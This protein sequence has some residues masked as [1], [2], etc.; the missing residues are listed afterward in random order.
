VQKLRELDR[1][2]IGVGVKA[3]TS[4][5]LP[6]ACDEFMFYDDLVNYT[7]ESPSDRDADKTADA[8]GGSDITIVLSTLAGLASSADM[9]RASTLKRA[10]LRKDPTFSEVSLGFRGFRALLTS[11]EEEGLLTVEGRGDPEVALSASRAADEAD[12]LL[13]EV[14]KTA[15]QVPLTGLKTAMKKQDPAF[16]EQ[17]L[18]YRN[19]GSFVRAAEVRNL[20]QVVGKGDDR[21]V[22][23]PRRRR[24]G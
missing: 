11:L 3:S 20:I 9:V 8:S 6:P 7:S 22:K 14:V 13:T 18:G 24:R 17:R 21:V 4:N 10:I 16:S 23:P 12:A 5:L 19:F 1:R 15:K 2:V